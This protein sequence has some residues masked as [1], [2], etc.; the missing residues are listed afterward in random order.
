MSLK[1]REKVKGS[2]QLKFVQRDKRDEFGLNAKYV[3]SILAAR[4]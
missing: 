3:V 2:S 1:K 4:T